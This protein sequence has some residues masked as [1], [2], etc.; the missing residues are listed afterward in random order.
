MSWRDAGS[1]SFAPNFRLAVVLSAII[2]TLSVLST[3]SKA[4]PQAGRLPNPIVP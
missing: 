1:P 2:L 3:P 4:E